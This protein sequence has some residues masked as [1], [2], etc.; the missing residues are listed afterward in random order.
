MIIRKLQNNRLE[1][2][3]PDLLDYKYFCFN[4][5]PK[6]CQVI[7]GRGSKMCIDFFDYDWKHQPFH[8]PSFFP[9]SEEV[10]QKP[11][12]FK[13]MWDA[14]RILSKGTAFSR[15]DFYQVQDHVYFGEIT[16]YPTTGM[17]GFSPVEY[18][19][20]LGGYINLD[21]IKKK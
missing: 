1:Y 2:V 13:K 7:S 4:G 9:F 11:S 21:S 5:E 19:T 14:A 12:Q 3:R 8:E 16:F 15:I 6:Y 18:D 20:I 10:I 17:G